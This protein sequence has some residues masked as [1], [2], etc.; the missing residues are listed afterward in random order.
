MLVDISGHSTAIARERARFGRYVS[1]R[2]MSYTNEL[3]N[4][5][6]R[7]I[8]E[9]T[10]LMAKKI[11]KSKGKEKTRAEFEGFANVE[12]TLEEKA[13]AKE[14]I[15]DAESVQVELDELLASGYK[16]S[17]FKSETTGGYQAT[18]FCADN[19]SPNAGYILSAFAPHWW[20]A[21]TM[22]AYKHA[23]KCEGVWPIDE[24]TRGDVWG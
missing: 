6:L 17:V 24:E 13:E 1:E 11:D 4:W 15:R 7:N 18:A 8:F 10:W 5:C 14:W 16:I 9:E 19:R 3:V 22:L 2:H 12:L 20:D 23:I 21:I